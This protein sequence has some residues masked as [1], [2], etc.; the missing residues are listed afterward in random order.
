MSLNIQGSEEEEESKSKQSSNKSSIK[1]TKP[2]QLAVAAVI[3]ANSGVQ[4]K[5][6]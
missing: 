3:P 5:P 2:S 6:L 4:K 1:Q